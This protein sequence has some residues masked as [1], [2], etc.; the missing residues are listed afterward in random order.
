MSEVKSWAYPAAAIVVI[1]YATALLLGAQ[2]GS[3]YSIP[4]AT[5]FVVGLTIAGLGIS[6]WIVLLLANYARQREPHPSRRLLVEG[7]PR[8]LAFLIGVVL[9]TLEMAVLMW[10]KVML[11]ITSPFWADPL[12]ADVD[13]AIFGADPWRLTQALMGWAGPFIDRMYV[14]WAPAK[15]MTLLFIF[16]RPEG[17][18]KAQAI[19]AYFL[20]VGITAISQYSLSSGGPIFYERL[21]FGSRFGELPFLPWVVAASDY[22]WTSYLNAGGEIGGGISAMP[23]LHVAVALWVALV[24]RSYAPKLQAIGW[25]YFVTI[26]VGSV[27]LGWH[28]AVDGIAALLIGV[29]AWSLAG[30]TRTSGAEQVGAAAL[31]GI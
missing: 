7:T 29:F 19:V 1:E 30:M 24:I 6:L 10:L 11:P 14:T 9:V 15:F 13:A 27:H 28:Y 3:H 16:S 12:L 25:A 18:R 20:M 2:M 8:F 23:S 21:G 26:L 4:F 22:L 17:P 5:Y 31:K